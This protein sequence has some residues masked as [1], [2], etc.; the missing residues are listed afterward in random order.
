MEVEEKSEKKNY[1]KMGC[2]IAILVLVIVIIAIYSGLI[3]FPGSTD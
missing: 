1:G 2:F 3:S